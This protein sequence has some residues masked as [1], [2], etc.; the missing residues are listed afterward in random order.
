MYSVDERYVQTPRYMI[1]R[2]VVQLEFYH[3]SRLDL[4]DAWCALSIFERVAEQEC[5][6]S[7]GPT[8]ASSQFLIAMREEE[9]EGE[10]ERVFGIGSGHATYR[11]PG[12]GTAA[13][14]D[15]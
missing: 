5:R 4:I 10:D 8:C 1:R 3:S 7:G 6:S 12:L 9:E 2:D 14:A 13:T 11:K 15:G